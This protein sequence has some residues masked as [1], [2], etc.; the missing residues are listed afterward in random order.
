M[1]GGLRAIG[2]A[3]AAIA[4]GAPVA[5]G[6]PPGDPAAEVPPG[7][8]VLDE[9]TNAPNS[10][11]EQLAA[12]DGW[13]AWSRPDPAT[14]D[15]ALVLRSPGG[16]IRLAGVPERALPFDVSI[17]PTA[18]GGDA[19]VYSRCADVGTNT[20]CRIVELTLGTERPT[21]MILRPPG[22]GSVHSPALYT[23]HL[24]FL[25]AIPGGGPRHPDAMFDWRFGTPHL[26]AFKLPRNSYT[27]AQLAADPGLRASDGATGAITSLS[28]TSSLSLD[29]SR[30]AYTRV[31]TVGDLTTSDTWIQS[32]EGTPQLIDRVNTGLAASG[33]HTYLSPTIINR[34]L[35]TLRQYADVGETYV[36]YSLVKDTAAEADIDLSRPGDYRVDSAVPA[37]IP[38]PAGLAWSLT[39]SA[40]RSAG[41]TLILLHPNITWEMIPR[42]AVAHLPAY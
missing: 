6:A 30:V 42:P 41:V 18:A 27:P 10:P 33:L 23:D 19:A 20:G 26:E 37:Y 32:P 28:L 39:N 25:R 12:G 34:S 16:A 5:A 40:G 4:L 15:Y 7:A 3:L 36:R 1:S 13:L 2:A 9:F 35:Y 21:E 24:A 31:A 22:G 11:P 29:G 17:G 14:G 38:D 8:F